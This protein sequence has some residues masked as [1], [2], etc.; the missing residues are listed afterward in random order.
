MGKKKAP[1][2][3]AGGGGA[4]GD[5]EADPPQ[6][7]LPPSVEL[8][9]TRVIAGPHTNYNVRSPL[10]SSPGPTGG[11]ACLRSAAALH[12]RCPPRV[13]LL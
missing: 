6:G 10:P 13:L 2:A 9:R 3:A 7:V 1:A 8:A 11:D 5:E 4:A 12:T